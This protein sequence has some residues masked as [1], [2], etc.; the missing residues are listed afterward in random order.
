MALKITCPHCSQ[1]RRLHSPYPL[2]G[3]EV[4]CR[5]CGRVLSISYPPGMV[6]KLRGKGVQFAE[7]VSLG[8]DADHFIAPPPDQ[9]LP[10]DP[11]PPD[12]GLQ[13]PPGFGA[14]ETAL[15]N[16]DWRED[17]DVDKTQPSIAPPKAPAPTPE[18]APAPKPPRPPTFKQTISPAQEKPA[19]RVPPTRERKPRQAA[20]TPPPPRKPRKPS[21]PE[22]PARP[23]KPPR[24]KRS[25]L[26]RL[27]RVALVLTLL[28][29][30]VGA[31][32]GYYAWWHYGQDLPTV[33]TLQNYTPPTVTTIFDRKGRLIGE[34]YEKRR[35]VIEKEQLFP[36]EDVSAADS[37]ACAQ[38]C[39]S[40]EGVE[41]AYQCTDCKIPRHVVDV[42]IAA[43]DANFWTHG[44][45][46]YEGILRAI[47]RNVSQG[48]KA[49]GASTITQQ[50]ARNFLLTNDKTFER[51][52]REVILAGRVEETFTKEHILYLY[53][54]QIY[55]GSGAYGVEAAART[56]F[57]KSAYQMTL[58]EAAI[59]AGLPQRP[60]DYSPHRNWDKARGRQTYVLR[61]ML[62]K[63]F[64]D[65]ATHD[66]AL[67]EVVEIKKADN[68]FMTQAPYFTEHARRYLVET[69]GFD[70][71]YNDGLVVNVTMDLDLQKVAQEAVVS[72]VNLADNRRGWRGAVETLEG[73]S[74]QT[75]LDT[76]E[77]A[78]REEVAQSVLRVA[79]KDGEGGY[80]P[81]PAQSTLEEGRTYE[82]VLTE[83]TQKHMIAGIGRHRVIIPRSWT[84]WAYDVNPDR[85]WR[86]RK[87]DDLT[88]AFS[89][90][91]RL[92][93]TVEH[94]DSQEADNL[95]GYDPAKGLP[96]GRVYQAPL[97]Q[98]AMFSYRLT[99]GAVLA[100]VGGV[101]F[102]DSE[103]NR[104]IQAS[105]Q[106]GSTFKPIV[107]AAAIQS[108]QFTAGSMVQD[109]PTVFNVL[110]G[111]LWKPGNYGGDYL[112][113]ITLRRALQM[114]RNVCTVRVLDKLGLEPVYQLAGPTLRI[115]YDE[116]SCS[117]THVPADAECEGTMTPSAVSGMAWCE[118]C[119]AT[120]CPLVEAEL[121]TVRKNGEDIPVGDPKTCL[122][123]P[124][125]Q[126]GRKWC[127]SCDVN[128]RACDWLPI[129]EIPSSDPCQDA[130]KDDSGQIWCRTCDLSMG[131]GSSSLTMVELSQAYSVFATYG[132]LVEPHF[133]ESVVDRD[134]TVIEEFEAPAE[135]PE[136]MDPSAAGIAHWMLREVATGGTAARTNRLGLHVAGK[137]GTTNDFF[138]A[139]FVGYNPDII[140]SA[141]VGFDKPQSI[142]S[143]FTGGKT[144]LPIWMDYMT[145]AAPKDKDRP[146]PAIPGVRM[147]A[148]DESTGNVANGGR[149]MPMLPGTA[150]TNVVGDIGQS[151][152]EDIL[153]EDF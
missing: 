80:G 106:V 97:L 126:G 145:V 147:V 6:E 13:P 42:F 114:S 152:A 141:W 129:Q 41:S 68:E 102:E 89:V 12:P 73:A 48:K 125:E 134:G 90:G 135:W 82:T 110:G 39:L 40:A 104:A 63:G 17:A 58:A 128:L 130:R 33:A 5:S 65:Q 15:F 36:L 146:F 94:L 88:N 3:S 2:P 22:E 150:P 108:R 67:A 51:K 60:S 127:H 144:A 29:A 14:Q 92:Q 24:K 20:P 143:S 74:I 28:G 72:N 55:L 103:Y 84:A 124:F 91:D 100:M 50:V 85:S 81:K 78:L 76:Q 115:G 138:D 45:V 37:D 122:D 99:D 87:Q 52:I 151:S 11:A 44:G 54:N 59:L 75:W 116:P 35:Y 1:P 95:K 38:E 70:K 64:I 142:G 26:G 62:Q 86:Y 32:G 96:A 56:Y 113:N 61:Q 139:W 136:V 18:P 105:R 107:Y 117:R 109:A 77:E 53:M 27:L 119:D 4:H 148:I 34:I 9:P 19:P 57:G 93:V 120:S 123:E 66:K 47:V 149:V 131:L 101:D 118:Y 46:D 31:G 133:I 10:R 137:T 83:V 7:P 21:K 112:G 153:T 69:Y 140:T 23:E 43:E 121:P 132:H 49:Q 30:V 79:A 111:K 8:V 16:R 25:L 98:G 71:V